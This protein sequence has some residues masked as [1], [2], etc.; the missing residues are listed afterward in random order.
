[1]RSDEKTRVVGM[2]WNHLYILDEDGNPKVAS[3]IE[4][5][6]WWET[7]DRHVAHTMIL[8]VEVS[9][10][11]LGINCNYSGV[12]PPVLWETMIFGELDINGFDQKQWRYSSKEAALKG[13]EEA[14]K[15]VSRV[16]VN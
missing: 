11:F 9:T 10:V 2:I 15:Q 13:H 8:N 12:G 16:L 4:W 1:M 7:A 5:A 6:V 3:P 14:V